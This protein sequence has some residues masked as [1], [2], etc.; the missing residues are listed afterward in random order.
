M[1]ADRMIRGSVGEKE[2]VVTVE[3]LCRRCCVRVLTPHVDLFGRC[4]G[5]VT[6]GERVESRMLQCLGRAGMELVAEGHVFAQTG[7]RHLAES[8]VHLE[9][10][11]QCTPLCDLSEELLIGHVLAGR[12]GS[13]G[14]SSAA[15]DDAHPGSSSRGLGPFGELERKACPVAVP[16]QH[17]VTERLCVHFLPKHVDECIDRGR[18][19]CRVPSAARKV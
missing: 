1:R 18:Q 10:S 11:W 3:G 6:T 16:Q 19:P 12:P 2:E 4:D 15:R 9:L 7:Y 8:R 5:V 14:R 13:S 17:P